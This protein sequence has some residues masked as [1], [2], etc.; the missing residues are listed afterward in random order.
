M[1][2]R[3]QEGLRIAAMAAAAAAMLPV[4]ASAN[5]KTTAIVGAPTAPR[6]QVCVWDGTQWVVDRDSMAN[7]LDA[8][9]SLQIATT[10][11]GTAPPN[12]FDPRRVLDVPESVFDGHRVDGKV[13]RTRPVCAYP[14]VARY[15]GSGSPDEA[16]N[17]SCTRP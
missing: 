15:N 9:N 12:R 11:D 4:A 6:E 7:W 3:C 8:S 17:F 13:V 1:T 14:E 2:S 10:R 5:A 16:A